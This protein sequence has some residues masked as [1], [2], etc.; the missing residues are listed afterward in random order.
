MAEPVA[1][2]TQAGEFDALAAGPGDGRPVLLLHGFPESAEQWEHQLGALAGAGYR[3]VAFD[4]RGYSPGV[5]PAEVDAY[6]PEELIGDVLAVA[7]ALGWSR[8]DL[9]GHDWGSAIAWMTAA[10]HPERL[11]TL[12]TVSTPHGAAL[13][14]ALRDDPDQRRRSAYFEQFRTPGEAERELIDGDGLRRIYD[15]LPAYRIE[16]YIERF[17][18]PGA[19]TA[20][21]NWYRA[22][23]PPAKRGPITTPTL[24]VWSTADAF[25]GEA[26][27]RGTERHV[28]GP[29]RFEVLDGVSHW[30]SEEAPERLSALILDH[31]AAW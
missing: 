25:I 16:R 11:R 20:A 18:E 22:M 5:R 26:A 14:D 3:A 15:G 4:Q 8:F 19:L 21:L 30:I 9:V 1:I 7:D 2:S 31:L 24:Y 23:R 27:A 28:E 17:S 13:R 6:G 10:A 12:T 29:Y